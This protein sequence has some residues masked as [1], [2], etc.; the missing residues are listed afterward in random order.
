MRRRTPRP[1]RTDTPF[2]Y[3]TLFRSVGKEPS[4]TP[5]NSLVQL[6]YEKGVPRNPFINAGALV[7]LDSVMA[8]TG[9]ETA[10]VI[11]DYARVLSRDFSID[12]NAKVAASEMRAAYRNAAIANLLRCRSEEHTSELQSLMRI[13][14]AV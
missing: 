10:Q 4:G 7:V 9:K 11:L 2:P 14:Y 6:E 12:Y 13:S 1:T 5:F 3:T 8:R